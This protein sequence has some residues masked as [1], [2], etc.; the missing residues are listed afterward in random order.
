MTRRELEEFTTRLLFA[1]A[2]HKCR[3]ER[4]RN[5]LFG[6]SLWKWRMLKRFFPELSEALSGE[7]ECH[8]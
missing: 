6:M 7:V 1:I 4:I 8:E 2:E 5:A 3:E